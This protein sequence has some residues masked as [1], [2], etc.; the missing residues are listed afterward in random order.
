MM[1]SSKPA[2]GASVV[3]FAS[4][5]KQREQKR[6]AERPFSEKVEEAKRGILRSSGLLF[7]LDPKPLAGSPAEV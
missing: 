7:V 1:P 3:D 6:T 5:R 4:V 2:D